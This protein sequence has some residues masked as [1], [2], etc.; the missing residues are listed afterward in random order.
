MINFGNV[1]FARKHFNVKV[2]SMFVFIRD[3]RLKHITEMI[4]LWLTEHTFSE[5]L[6]NANISESNSILVVQTDDC[7]DSLNEKVDVVIEN[8]I[9]EIDFILQ[10]I[11]IRIHLH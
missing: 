5:L 11:H 10:I 2:E 4:M 9:F 1:R 7:M 3:S 8:I 6:E